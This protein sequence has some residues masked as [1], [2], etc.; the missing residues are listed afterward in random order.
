MAVR[1]IDLGVFAAAQLVLED[2]VDERQRVVAQKLV[3]A[4]QPIRKRGKH[5]QSDIRIAAH[6]RKEVLAREHSQPC[7]LRHNRVG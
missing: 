1:V 6:K 2:D 5:F 3:R 4:S 7:A